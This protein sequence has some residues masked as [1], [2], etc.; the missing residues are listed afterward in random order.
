LR[1]QSPQEK[2]RGEGSSR[3]YGYTAGELE[4]NP[5][6]MQA[7]HELSIDAGRVGGT[8]FDAGWTGGRTGADRPAPPRGGERGL[9]KRTRGKDGYGWEKGIVLRAFMSG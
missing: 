5:A 4:A 2:G 6:H 8:A 3:R 9:V 7:R 1:C